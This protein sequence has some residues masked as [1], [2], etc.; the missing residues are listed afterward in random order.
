M[1]P[2]GNY[3][4]LLEMVSRSS[5]KSPEEIERLVEAKRAR[6]SGLISKEGAV[7]IIASELGINF[8]KHKMKISELA[9]GMR[10]INIVGKI[11]TINRVIEYNKN[12]RSGKIGSLL[13]GDETGN[14]RVVLWDVNHISLIEGGKL[15]EGGVIEISG[16]DIRNG[17]L[18]LGSFAD[19]KESKVVIN[20]VISKPVLLEK[21]ISDITLN[22]NVV[23]RAFVVQVFGPSFFEVCPECGKKADAGN[24]AEH[25]IIIPK[26]KAIVN[27]VLDDGSASI[28]GVLFNDQIKLIASE[29]DIET[30]ES[31]MLKRVELLGA[32][33]YVEANVRKNK[34]SEEVELIVAGFKTIS[35]V[36]V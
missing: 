20:Q 2:A 5:G 24:C 14:I 3:A 27:L 25:G 13:L 22:D 26:K 9:S 4:Q 6:L 34:F 8:E 19:L 29:K 11:I 35:N 30:K 12:G 16:G 21:K 15:K 31:F 33:Y 32:E 17:E 18:H 23:V 1:L 10:K 36:N 28:R 7:Q